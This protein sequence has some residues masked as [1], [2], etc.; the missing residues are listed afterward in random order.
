MNTRI[1]K[2]VITLFAI[3]FSFSALPAQNNQIKKMRE[4]AGSLRKEITEKEKILLSSQKDVKSRLNNLDIIN[5]QIKDVKR[6][7]AML[8]NEV[9][10]VDTEISMLNSEIKRQELLIEQSRKEYAEALRRARKYS[11]FHNKLTFIF[12]AG[13]FNTMLRR[14]RYA[15]E[16]MDAHVQL[17][18]RLKFQINSLEIKRANLQATR[19]L[20]TQSLREQDTERAKLQSLEKEQRKIVASLRKDAK[21]VETELKK[22]RADLQKLNKAI[23]REIERIIAEEKAAKKRAEEEARKRAEAAKSSSGTTA[24]SS[25]GYKA[26][27]GVDAMSGS[28]L[29][30]KKKL[31]VPITG[32]Y[33]VVEGYGVKNAISGKGNVPINTG[34]ITLEGGKGAQAR[35]IFDG[36]V[37]AVL[38]TGNY[39]FVLVRHGKYISVYCNLENVRV[40][41]GEEIKAGDIIGDIAV[42]A[43]E[44]NPRM[45]FQLRQEKTKLNPAEWLK[46]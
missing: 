8:Q 20:K 26:D 15:N 19:L 10:A 30:N 29:N 21:K 25:S 34:G 31:P 33:L 7:I 5:A 9:K 11:N 41:G 18:E 3:I 13:D 38:D 42:D 6:L 39:T 28:F 43:K 45:L 27:T 35:C 16:Y 24:K 4:Q 32:P 23:D 12:S 44:G 40:S 17:A 1:Q 22:K 14:Y 2:I 46:M 36:K 37:T